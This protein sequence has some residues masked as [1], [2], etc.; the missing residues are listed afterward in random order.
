MEHCGRAGGQIQGSEPLG[1][2]MNYAKVI[3]LILLIPSLSQAQDLRDYIWMENQNCYSNKTC[4]KEYEKSACNQKVSAGDFDGG[5]AACGRFLKDKPKCGAAYR[6]RALAYLQKGSFDNSISD[7]T[8]AIDLEPDIWLTYYRRSG[9]FQWKGDLDS[10]LKDLD[11]AIFLE[12]RASDAH[13]D[14]GAIYYRLQ[15]YD[16]AL[17][18]FD[19]AIKI[20]P[21]SIYQINRANMLAELRRKDEALQQYQQVIDS[22]PRDW[23]TYYNLGMALKAYGYYQDAVQSFLRANALSEQ[24]PSYVELGNSYMQAGQFDPARKAFQR[25]SDMAPLDQLEPISER[26]WESFYFAGNYSDALQLALQGFNRTA[27][28]AIK[29]AWKR[30]LGFSHLALANFKIAAEMLQQAK[31]LGVILL[32]ADGGL[33][34]QRIYKNGPA[35]LAG[36]QSGDILLEIN[37]SPL[38]GALARISEIMDQK[39]VFGT[40]AN[41]RLIRNGAVIE[42]QVLVG[43]LANL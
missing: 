41:I 26:I 29:S 10:A 24:F 3:L 32:A 25:A 1:D 30:N 23:Q 11:M 4:G 22:K 39:T 5:I 40:R 17:R 18:D 37:G 42:T 43:V 16:R 28:T 19:M 9:A 6:T 20:H 7:L 36:L 38:A 33:E 8:I 21:V 27:D 31:I 2:L 35:D 15:R 13:N 34:V 14:R 12:P